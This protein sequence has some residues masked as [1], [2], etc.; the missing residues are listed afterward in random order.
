MHQE[1]FMIINGSSMKLINVIFIILLT[2]VVAYNDGLA[3]DPTDYSAGAIMVTFNPEE[4]TKNT[5]VTIAADNELEYFETFYIGIS[6]TDAILAMVATVTSP[7]ETQVIIK[8][9]KSS[10]Y[11]HDK[12]PNLSW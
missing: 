2:L 1:D 10:C 9:R 11:K 4:T 5:M 8:D 6:I 7:S 12:V 3:R